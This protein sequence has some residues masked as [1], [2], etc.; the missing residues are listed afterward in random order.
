M[1]LNGTQKSIIE[2][3]LSTYLDN[4]LMFNK[5]EA[6]YA[7]SVVYQEK[8]S[9]DEQEI[10]TKQNIWEDVLFINQILM[11]P[12]PQNRVVNYAYFGSSDLD[13]IVYK[14]QNGKPAFEKKGLLGLTV[15]NDPNTTSVIK[16][17]VVQYIHQLIDIAIEQKKN[18]G[19]INASS[20]DSKFFKNNQNDE[21]IKQIKQLVTEEELELGR[22]PIMSLVK[23]R[24]VIRVSFCELVQQFRLPP[25]PGRYSSNPFLHGLSALL[26]RGVSLDQFLSINKSN[27]ISLTVKHSAWRL[28]EIGIDFDKLVQLENEDLKKIFVW[29]SHNP[30]KVMALYDYEKRKDVAAEIN[31]FIDK[32][33]DT[34]LSFGHV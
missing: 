9:V 8:I 3:V 15:W 24:S 13:T 11:H 10:L 26:L 34:P 6:L 4:I 7:L 23:L 18:E 31:T 20:S 27:Q 12:C 32:T 29:L 25:K 28:V 5:S 2:S 19:P 17:D 14:D 21:I 30:D 16:E 33:L 1:A 22:V